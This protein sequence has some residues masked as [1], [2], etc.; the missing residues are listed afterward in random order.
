MSDIYCAKCGE[1]WDAWGVRNGD[2][3]EEEAKL[4]LKGMGCPACGFEHDP[5]AEGGCPCYGSKEDATSLLRRHLESA[6]DATDEP[7]E[8]LDLIFGGGDDE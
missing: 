4:F 3:T 8:I 7:D 5:I 6:L 2:M 1:P